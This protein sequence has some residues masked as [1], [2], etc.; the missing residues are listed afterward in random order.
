MTCKIENNPKESARNGYFSSRKN[1]KNQVTERASK[2]S[3]KISINKSQRKEN[4]NE[5]RNLLSY[6]VNTCALKSNL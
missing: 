4:K 3:Q 2:R 5:A 1:S 6:T